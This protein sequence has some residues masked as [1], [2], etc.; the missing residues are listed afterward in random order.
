M[1]RIFPEATSLSSIVASTPWLLPRA[2]LK[3]HLVKAVRRERGIGVIQ[4]EDLIRAGR[5]KGLARPAG[6]NPGRPP[7]PPRGH[8]SARPGTGQECNG[9]VLE[10]RK[11]RIG[12]H[13]KTGAFEY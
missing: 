1:L 5:R 8:R 7:G 6:Q 12:V 9:W 11:G 2:P 3:N 4:R 13:R 10:N